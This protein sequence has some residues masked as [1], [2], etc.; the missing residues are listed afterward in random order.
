MDVSVR[1]LVDVGG[2]RNL[3]RSRLRRV[4]TPQVFE[5]SLIRQGYAGDFR[6]SFT[7]DASVVESMGVPIHLVEG[8]KRNIKIT[9]LDD[10]YMAA[11][12]L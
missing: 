2:S 7:D 11:A 5:L 9:T 3:E 1:Q 4:Q 8:E 12:L 10:M 6:Q